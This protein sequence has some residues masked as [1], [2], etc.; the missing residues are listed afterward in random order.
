[1]YD[2][3]EIAQLIDKFMAGETSIA[4]ENVLAQY[5]RIHEV[6]KEWATYKEMFA[7]FDAGEVDI[8]VKTEMVDKSAT[9]QRAKIIEFDKSDMEHV[10]PQY[11][12]RISSVLRWMWPAVVGCM[13][14]AFFLERLWKASE[15]PLSP[16]LVVASTKVINASTSDIT[17]QSPALVD[18][19]I[20]KLASYNGIEQEILDCSSTTDSNNYLYVFPDK[21]GV[22]VFAHLL[23]VACWYNN[24]IPGYQLRLSHEEFFFELNDIRESR[25]HRWQAEKIGNNIFLYGVNVPIGMEISNTCYMDFRDKYT[26]S[27]KKYMYYEL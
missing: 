8:T 16:Q 20:A 24:A 26:P 11:P 13:V 3:K 15:E 4:E 6:S 27:S 17:Y 21:I 2:K 23:Q 25:R 7:L 18:E 12:H 1:M 9:P 19:F 5:F 22:D 14:L 10:S